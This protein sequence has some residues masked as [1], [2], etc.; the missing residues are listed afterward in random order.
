MYKRKT[1]HTPPTDVWEI[2]RCILK[3]NP[4]ALERKSRPCTGF[5]LAINGDLLNSAV[6]SR[7]KTSENM[8]TY[9]YV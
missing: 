8:Y 6:Y 5:A 4:N 7:I 9:M 2:E 1:L 3:A